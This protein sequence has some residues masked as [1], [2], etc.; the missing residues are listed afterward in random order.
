MVTLDLGAAL[1]SRDPTA[2]SQGIFGSCCWCGL[3]PA[4][5]ERSKGNAP[6]PCA[7]LGSDACHPGSGI[8][9]RG[10]LGLLVLG[11]GS[12]NA[13]ECHGTGSG[14]GW[15]SWAALSTTLSNPVL[16]L[17]YSQRLRQSFLEG[18]LMEGAGSGAEEGKGRAGIVPPL[19]G[20]LAS[21]NPS[22]CPCLAEARDA[23]FIF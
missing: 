9:A 18:N 4:H 6:H 5:R 22:L 11:D 15:E 21:R 7:A 20:A 10:G 8:R 16:T 23:L 13:W 14:P 2:K 3:Q 17:F 12:Y 19:P 1:W